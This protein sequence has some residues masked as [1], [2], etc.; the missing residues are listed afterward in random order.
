MA[1]ASRPCRLLRGGAFSA[2]AFVLLAVTMTMMVMVAMTVM[3]APVAQAH[4]V[5][6]GDDGSAAAVSDEYEA[7][8]RQLR[9]MVG[10]VKSR[11][12]LDLG[13]LMLEHL[14]D[15]PDRVA[16][17]HELL[18]LEDAAGSSRRVVAP[19]AESPARMEARSVTASTG[20]VMQSSESQN[21]PVYCPNCEPAVSILTPGTC[22]MYNNQSSCCTQKETDALLDAMGVPLLLFGK[23]PVCYV[24]RSCALSLWLVHCIA[25]SCP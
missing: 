24:R 11:T 5:V 8:W 14:A 13:R 19:A 25:D 7:H 20:C 23:C 12:G 22:L 6:V 2:M 21:K 18:G 16:I 10:D 17:M 1:A 15:D 9:D 3:L 4:V